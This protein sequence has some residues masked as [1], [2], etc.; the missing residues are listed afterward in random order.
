[1]SGAGFERL[2]NPRAIAIVGASDNPDR[3][4]GQPV[5]ILQDTGYRGAIYPVN[6]KYGKVLGLPCFADL[7]AVPKPCDLA[8]IAVNAA[9]VPQA[10]LDCGAAGIP[11]AVVFS[12][13]F[14][15][16]GASGAVLEEKMKAAARTAGVRFIGPNCLG[17]MNLLERVYC[18]FGQGFANARLKSGTVAFVSQ[19]GGFAFSVVALAEAEGVGF[20]YVIS[21]GN[22]ASISSLDL[23][24][25]FLE[26]DDT[27]IVVSYIEGIADGRRLREIGRR[28]LELGKPILVWKVGNTERGRVA[29][30][31]HTASMT[32]GYAL[33][34][35]AFEEGGFI[36]IHDVDDLVDGVR[37][38]R[39]QRLPRGP[40]LG[41][42]TTSGGSGVL[43]VDAAERHGLKFPR[44]APETERAVK[45]L[46]PPHATLANPVDLTAQVT[47]NP[48]WVNR[49][50]RLVLADPNL[51]QLIIRYG[52]VQ[53]A[54]GEVWA[55]GLAA[56]V[57]EVE[58]PVLV[59]WSRVP[60]RSERSVQILEEH[61]IP[62]L[63]TPTRA[64][65]AAGM[66]YQFAR[67]RAAHEEHRKRR[68]GRAVAR[69]A[70]KLPARA[71]KLSEHQSKAVLSAY[72][73]PVPAEALIPVATIAR[74]KRAPLPFPVAVKV[75]SPDIPHKTEAGAVRLNVRN[76]AGLKRAAREVV[77]AAKLH[78]PG[79]AI[80]GV[81]VSPMASGIELI[82]GATNDRFFGPVVMFG[83]GGIFTEVL[84]DVSYRFAPFDI[85]T[86]HEM[87]RET[88]AWRLLA[89]YRGRPPLAV[90]ALAD[91]LARL[92]LLIA[93]HADRIA[94]IDINPLFVSE[95]H[96]V[97][98]DALVVLRNRSSAKRGPS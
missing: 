86:A 38:F 90:D 79:A 65:D 8:I 10:L 42:L 7:A 82:A 93:D 54:K 47:G 95:D 56:L 44:L 48:E 46:A 74:L 59:G 24:A 76:L 37:A 36:E 97:P 96:V 39:S 61:R 87:I 60:D 33:Y 21:A 50:T 80:R 35:A 18:G 12:A 92:S 75:D 66:L 69:R 51:D 20:N 2:F 9:I 68:P 1:M 14:R 27:E 30:E 43:M 45:E 63:V 22:E 41:V 49:L 28:A 19:S 73:I 26:R 84:Q 6:P 62:W 91:A 23:I 17:T 57:S 11:H 70:L 40:H 55:N 13:G 3:I 29:A 25:D 98:A 53:G 72:G 85:E 58:K 71:E 83:L 31:S 4:G 64:A 5:K 32:A 15:E 94:E 77:A 89:G 34:R 88:R 67:K 78:A 81:L 52:T 16:I